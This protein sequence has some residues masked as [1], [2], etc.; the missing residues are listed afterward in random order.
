MKSPRHSSTILFFRTEYYDLSRVGRLKL[1]RKL[2]IFSD[3][4]PLSLRTL[5]PEDIMLAVKYLLELK[6]GRS[7]HEIDDIDHMGNRRVRSVGELLENQYRIGLVQYGAGN[8]GA[9]E[10]SGR[11]NTNAARPDQC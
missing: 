3:E 11:G 1:N 5:R 6:E 9:N 10:S 8:K 2:G 4:A 7:G